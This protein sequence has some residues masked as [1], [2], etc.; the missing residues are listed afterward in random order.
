LKE[1]VERYR[2]D[3]V[4]FVRNVLGVEPDPWQADV[5]RA[6]QRSGSGIPKDR[7]ISIRSGHG[8]GKSTVCSWIIL[9]R[10]L[11][12][13][14]QKTVCTAPTASQLFDALFSEVKAWVKS[15]P[16]PLQE[17][18]DVISDRISL[19][20]APHESFVS[21]RTSR[22]EQ[23]DALQGVHSEHVLLV[24]DEAA[25]ISEQVY[26]AAYSS[27]SAASACII[28]I[29]NPTR[30]SGYFSDTFGR[31]SGEWTNFHVNCLDSPRVA[32]AF[33]AEMESRYGSSSNV[34]RTRVLGEF[35]LMEDDTLIP[36]D[37]VRGA[38]DRD[39]RPNPEA[40]VVWGLDIARMGSDH[41]ALCKRRQNVVLEP[42]RIF[43]KLDLM[44]LTG[45]IVDEFENCAP[46]DQPSEICCDVIGIGAGVV[47]RLNELGLPVRGVN[48]A[49][50]P[51]MGLRYLNLRM[52]LWHRAKD[53]FESLDCSI[54]ADSRLIQDLTTPRYAFSSTGKMKLESKDDMKKRGA[55]SPD[56]GD[57]FCLSLASHSGGNFGRGPKWGTPVRRS[58]TGLF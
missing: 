38:I 4:G 1:F 20:D 30:G 8:T 15:L 35:P 31:L 54:P 14:P 55:K 58:L 6:Y 10:L 52:E 48:V 44:D 43:H 41:S 18:L 21:A 49:E 3:P 19:K 13:F 29:G 37:L 51:S 23:P 50:A 47:D 27:M 5:M 56:A 53:W 39:V 9:H 28:L 36:V 57:A 2:D 16:E 22:S 34:Y 33:I 32:P 25:A 7:K 45:R 24:C 17:T 11:H 46:E 26:E 40:P 42:V 12:F